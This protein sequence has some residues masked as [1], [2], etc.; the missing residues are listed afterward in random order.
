MRRVGG[1]GWGGELRKERSVYVLRGA[2]PR[3]ECFI[4]LSGV[5]YR[6]TVS[7][8][9]YT[10]L[11]KV[12]TSRPGFKPIILSVIYENFGQHNGI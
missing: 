6:V 11:I 3:S 9:C 8:K 1:G 12:G 2:W 5:S 4:G 10:V 7:V